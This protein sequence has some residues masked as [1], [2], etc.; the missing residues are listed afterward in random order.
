MRPAG[1]AFQLWSGT[2]IINCVVLVVFGMFSLNVGLIFMSILGFFLALF[3][4]CPLLVP[5]TF[6]VKWSCKLP[7]SHVVKIWWLGFML[8]FLNFIFFYLLSQVAPWP[9][10]DLMEIFFGSSTAALII[11]LYYLRKIIMELYSEQTTNKIS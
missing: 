5:A 11:M 8:V 6:L 7:Y 1:I 2:I 4:S 9:F 10:G 3:V